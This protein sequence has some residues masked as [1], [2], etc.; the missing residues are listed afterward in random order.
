MKRIYEKPA[1][2]KA[3]VRLQAVTA[4]PPSK[5]TGPALNASGN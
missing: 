2:A 3:P 5:T 4:A 1:L